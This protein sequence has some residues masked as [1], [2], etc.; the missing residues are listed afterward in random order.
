MEKESHQKS[1]YAVIPAN[2]RY[3]K[4][5]SGNEKLLFGEITA[6]TNDRGYCFA[7]NGYF[8]ELYGVAKETVSKWVRSLQ[9][10]GHIITFEHITQ[11][12]SQRRIRLTPLNENVNPPCEKDQHP[13]TKT[14]TPLNENVKH[15]NTVNNKDNN[16]YN[17]NIELHDFLKPEFSKCF[18]EFL[19]YRKKIKKP[20]K[21]V[22]FKKCYD[23]LIELSKNDP[24]AAQKIIDQ[25]IA[26]S[27]TGL[28]ELKEKNTKEKSFA[29][30]EN[31]G[32]TG[33]YQEKK[34]NSLF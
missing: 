24:N 23:N 29:K 33:E 22:S 32:I 2:V 18:L 26:N 10:A 13:L 34:P 30:K 3:D 28:F 8:A 9:E 19:D 4:R 16:T 7:S 12:G 14:L 6:L 21:P 27:W 5:L 15:N 20:I 25:S 11:C 1:Y 17:K 31:N